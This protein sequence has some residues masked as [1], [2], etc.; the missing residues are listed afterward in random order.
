MAIRLNDADI[1]CLLTHLKTNKM[2]CQNVPISKQ[3]LVLEFL[4]KCNLQPLTI[5]VILV[6]G[7]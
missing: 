5:Y 2:L 1:D 7:F 3:I 4:Q 6:P